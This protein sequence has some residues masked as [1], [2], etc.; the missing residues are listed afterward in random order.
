MV[1]DVLHFEIHEC[2]GNGADG[3][4][5]RHCTRHIQTSLFG[6]PDDGIRAFRTNRRD[7]LVHQHNIQHAGPRASELAEHAMHESLYEHVVNGGRE[8]RIQGVF[9]CRRSV[10][11]RLPNAAIGGNIV[12]CG[13]FPKESGYSVNP[14]HGVTGARHMR[15]D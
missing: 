5:C 6:F 15:Q 10:H 8:T 11:A 4:Q 9:A 3:E 13:I 12:A 7:V 2:A 14:M 1:G